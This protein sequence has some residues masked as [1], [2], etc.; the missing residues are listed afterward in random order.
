[1]TSDQP[2]S[3]DVALNDLDEESSSSSTKTGEILKPFK[4]RFRELVFREFIENFTPAYFG[5]VLGVGISANILYNFPYPSEWLRVCGQ[6]MFGVTVIFFLVCTFSCIIGF[7]YYPERIAM[8]HIHPLH[9]AFM[10]VYVMGFI[11]IINFI[12][13][14]VGE[15]HSIF[16]WVLWWIAVFM[17]AYCS[18]IIFFFAFISKFNKPTSLEHMHSVVL[19]PVVTLAVVSSSGHVV[20]NSLHSLDHKV[21]TEV[22]AIIFWGVC[23]VMG[24]GF[25]PIYY[26]R[27]IIYKLPNSALILTNFLPV[28]LFGQCSYSIY[29]FGVNMYNL[30]PDKMVG[31]AFLVSC[32][33][34]STVLLGFG[35]FSTFLGAV[36]ILSKVKPFAK[37]PNPTFTTKYG[38]LT[39]HK[40]FWAMNFPLGTM[41]LAS[42]EVGRG[43]VGNYPLLFFKIISCIYA[44]VLFLVTL[45]NLLGVFLHVCDCLKELF[46]K[47]ENTKEMV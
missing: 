26:A 33:L 24:A 4:V 45:G 17:S 2:I 28:G 42:G 21:I 7:C 8:Y 44:V 41:C 38:L 11:T 19:L 39:W 31:T 18:C 27:L 13:Y 25:M 32:G 35:Y 14:L 6:I 3:K 1:M 20:S 23:V 29:L 36:S 47:N 10:A 46:T 37:K 12:H 43:A 5:C 30:I 22:I 34:F 15:S 40:G 9:A 16:V